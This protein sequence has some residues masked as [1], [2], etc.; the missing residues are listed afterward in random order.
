MEFVVVPAYNEAKTIGPVLRGLFSHG[1]K[2]I[3]V[4]DDGS[5]DDTSLQA[6]A[7]GAHVIKHLVNRGQGAALQTGTHYALQHDADYIIHFDADDQFDAADIAPSLNV[8]KTKQLDVV[9][10]SRFL[11]NRSQVP[12]LKRLVLLPLA[13]VLNFCLT[14]VWLSDAHNGF[15]I[16]TR[17]AAQSITILQDGMAHNTEI[18][19]EVAEKKLRFA[20]VPICV[21]YHEFGQGFLGGVQVVLDLLIGRLP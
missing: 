11:D 8:L 19:A 14:G 5:S 16:L 13:R 4:V 9:F 12:R 1:Y 2:N 21:R 17:R 7:Q 18:L 3:V 6:A 15:R 10:G 20:E